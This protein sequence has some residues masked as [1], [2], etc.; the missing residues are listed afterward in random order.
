MRTVCFGTSCMFSA[1]FGTV[2]LSVYIIPRIPVCARFGIMFKGNFVV[3]FNF[4]TTPVQH[5]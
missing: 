4:F 3:G 5:N 2:Y 1:V